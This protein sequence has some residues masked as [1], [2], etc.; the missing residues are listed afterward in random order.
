MSLPPIASPAVYPF[1]GFADARRRQ[2]V[3][4][5]TTAPLDAGRLSDAEGKGSPKAMCA[6]S[7]Q[8]NGWSGAPLTG[9]DCASKVTNMGSGNLMASDV[10]KM[11]EP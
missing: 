10:V 6:D 9:F 8:T 2:Q 7:I 4:I 5:W 11:L 1:L 3:G